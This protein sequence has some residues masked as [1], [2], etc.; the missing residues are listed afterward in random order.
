MKD[1]PKIIY[2]NVGCD[3]SDVKDFSELEEVTWNKERVNADD[4]PYQL[5]PEYKK[6]K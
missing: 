6:F 4:I 2:L 5:K 1:I 3:I